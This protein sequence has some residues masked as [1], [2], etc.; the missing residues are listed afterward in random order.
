[1]RGGKDY[2]DDEHLTLE[3]LQSELE[4]T[5]EILIVPVPGFILRTGL[6]ETW[7]APNPGWMQYDDGVEIDQEGN[8]EKVNGQPLDISKVYKVASIVDFWRKRDSPTIGAYFE[9]N[10]SQL[11][12][13][14]SGQPIHALLIRL[15]AMGIWSGIW[16]ALNIDPAEGKIHEDAFAR[17]DFDGD[18][19]LSRQDIQKAIQNIA[20]FET[21]CGQ[22]VIVNQMFDE[23]NAF[24]RD[25]S[26]GDAEH[27]GP[28][29]LAAA[30]KHFSTSSLASMGDLG[31]ESDEE[32]VPAP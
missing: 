12:E 10:P 14:D 32:E 15:F 16:K 30:A 20:G 8:V 5:K 21:F 31:D 9:V 26:A 28:T 11:P 25:I 19:K 2:A 22:D 6:R 29:S 23:I 4:E 17:M 27:I 24:K 7:E 3:V 1:M 13:H 18:G